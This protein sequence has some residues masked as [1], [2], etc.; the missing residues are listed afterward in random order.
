LVRAIGRRIIFLSRRR[1]GR[2][3]GLLFRK[4]GKETMSLMIRVTSEGIGGLRTNVPDGTIRQIH[5]PKSSDFGCGIKPRHLTGGFD[6][7]SEIQGKPEL[8]CLGGAE[9]RKRL[10]RKP[11]FGKVENSS[12]FVAENLNEPELCR[13]F[14]CV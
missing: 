5:E 14:S 6:T 1:F 13:H 12:A 8:Q 9:R 2:A 3:D 11:C 7:I 10:E 4:R